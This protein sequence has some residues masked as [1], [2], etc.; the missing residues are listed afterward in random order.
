LAIND[1]D[2]SIQTVFPYFEPLI[3]KKVKK[4]IA[5]EEDLTKNDKLSYWESQ[6]NF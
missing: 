2:Y 1:L 4:E 3:I 5:W 6:I